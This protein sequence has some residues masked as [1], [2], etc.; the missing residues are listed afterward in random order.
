M[1]RFFLVRYA[2]KFTAVEYVWKKTNKTMTHNR[3]FSR[4]VDLRSA[5]GAKIPPAPGKPGLAERSMSE[6][7]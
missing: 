7:R 6:N 5:F 3:C 1:K 2:P 4:L